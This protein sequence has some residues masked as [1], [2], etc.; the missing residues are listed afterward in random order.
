MSKKSSLTTEEMDSLLEDAEEWLPQIPEVEF[1]EMTVLPSSAGTNGATEISPVYR[2]QLTTLGNIDLEVR[3]ELGRTSMLLQD[4]TR[5][6]RGS[7]VVLDRHV[8][9]PVQVLING[10]VVA[11]GKLIVVDGKFSVQLVEFV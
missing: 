3:I 7:V 11:R 9:E 10:K 1:P 4:V 8:D 6:S 5:L 2:Q